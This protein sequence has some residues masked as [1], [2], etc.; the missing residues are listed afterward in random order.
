M[1][2]HYWT[3]GC[4][5]AP[6]C[7]CCDRVIYACGVCGRTIRWPSVYYATPNN[8]CYHSGVGYGQYFPLEGF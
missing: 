5:C 1:N 6:G 4:G 3:P 7:Q 2:P 8:I